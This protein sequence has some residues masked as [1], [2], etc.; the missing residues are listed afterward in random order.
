MGVST[1]KR[2]NFAERILEM[3][4]L[5]EHFS[6]EDGGD[7]GVVRAEQLHAHLEQGTVGPASTMIGDR[8]VD[9]EGARA[10]GLGTV[11]VLWGHG[12]R[13]KLVAAGPDRLLES[14]AE[15]PG[16]QRGRP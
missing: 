8:A 12:T 15:L 9:I 4:G 7:V 16:L 11:G 6:F 1:S 2:K 5:R 3:F 14:P 10:N 13:V